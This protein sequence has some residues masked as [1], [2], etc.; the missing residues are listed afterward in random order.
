MR[1]LQVLKTF[2]KFLWLLY[3]F[4]YLTIFIFY[5]IFKDCSP[6]T[7]IMKDRLYSP[8]CIGLAKNFIQFSCRVVWK[9][10]NK[11][12]GHPNVIHPCSLSYTSHPPNPIV[13]LPSLR[14]YEWT[15]V[16]LHLQHKEGTRI[17]KAYNLHT[18]KCRK[19]KCT[20]LCLWVSVCIFVTQSRYGTFFSTPERY[21]VWIQELLTYPPRPLEAY[22]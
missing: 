18:V 8:C 1:I 16:F 4:I 21:L 15:F 12:F 17:L 20:S 7:V 5:I 6:F 14:H 10:T 19:H 13:P 2:S 9:N 22:R 11:L 3:L